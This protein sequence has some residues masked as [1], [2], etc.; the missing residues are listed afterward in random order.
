[1]GY[2]DSAIS[3]LYDDFDEYKARSG[4]Y[5]IYQGKPANPYDWWQRSP[6][7]TGLK[8]I[9]LRMV[10]MKSS[11]ANTERLFSALGNIQTARKNKMYVSTL[12]KFMK[13]RLEEFSND[14]DVESIRRIPERVSAFFCY[15]P[16]CPDGDSG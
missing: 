2:N 8:Q 10:I 9:A 14:T 13:I 1:M 11:S 7:S 16:K 15:R 12:E 5:S 6:S 3:A 4:R